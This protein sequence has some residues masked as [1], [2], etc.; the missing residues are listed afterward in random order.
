M[1]RRVLL[2]VLCLVPSVSSAGDFDPSEPVFIQGLY[3]RYLVQWQDD[4]EGSITYS[5][6]GFLDSGEYAAGGLRYDVP[7]DGVTPRVDPPPIQLRA[8]NFDGVAKL[9][10]NANFAIDENDR[11]RFDTDG[12]FDLD[13][14]DLNVIR[15]N[16]GDSSQ[17][18]LD[19][20]GTVGIDDLNIARN[21][22]GTSFPFSLKPAPWEPNN[23]RTW[24]WF[25]GEVHDDCV[26][27]LDARNVEWPYEFVAPCDATAVPEP[28][29]F[30]IA[31]IA[32]MALSRRIWSKC[33]Q[34]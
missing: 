24:N 5:F 10:T 18:D 14:N 26:V 3:W 9:D 8:S 4:T 33:R 21:G 32:I 27:L 29:T 7:L 1:F 25:Y 22:F 12:D 15:N 19:G 34:S 30:A 6:N 23:S 2:A 16:F 28:S 11:L 20:S 31:G 13:I 17:A